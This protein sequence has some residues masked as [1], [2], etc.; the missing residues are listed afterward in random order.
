M[1]NSYNYI[2]MIITNIDDSDMKINKMMSMM[3]L[4]RMIMK[5]KTNKIIL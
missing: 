5:K 3:M 1:S 2:V 4:T